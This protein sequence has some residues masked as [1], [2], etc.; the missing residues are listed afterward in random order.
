MAA[1]PREVRRPPWEAK[2]VDGL[3]ERGEGE[4]KRVVMVLVV[5]GNGGV[6]F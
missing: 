5:G 6:R 3:G 4:C 2:E 1:G